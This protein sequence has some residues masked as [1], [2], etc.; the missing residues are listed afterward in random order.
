MEG[1]T[2]APIGDRAC[3]VDHE[4]GYGGRL[5][6]GKTPIHR[7][8]EIAD[9]HRAVDDHRAVRLGAN[10]GDHHIVL[11]GNVA[12]DLFQDVFQRHHALD[13]AVLV[14]HEREV[15]SCGGGRP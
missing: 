3:F 13:L 5:S 8:V 15:S 10:A 14:D 2:L 11:V 7:A 12:D 6:V 1:E 4:T 9:R